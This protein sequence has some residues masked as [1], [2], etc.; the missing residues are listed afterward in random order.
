MNWNTHKG[1]ELADEPIAQGGINLN[2]NFERL[3]DRQLYL[4][5][6]KT[7]AYTAV[8][9]DLV[10]VDTSSANVT[11][12]LP[13]SPV[14]ND[15]IGV[16]LQSAGS[17]AAT[18]ARNGKKID[19]LS[20]DWTLDVSGAIVVL[21]Y[22]AS[23]GDWMIVEERW[24]ALVPS[25]SPAEGQALFYGDDGAAVW[26]SDFRRKNAVFNPF[27]L[28]NQRGEDPYSDPDSG[29]YTVDRWNVQRDDDAVVDVDSVTNQAPTVAQAGYRV[30]SSI[31]LAVNTTAD[32]SLGAS[33]YYL[34][35]QKIEGYVWSR[36]AQRD[37]TLSFW[38][39]SSKT[40]TYCVALRNSGKD[41]CYVAEY[42]IDAADTWEYKTISISAS[43]SA[44]TWN[45]ATSV[46]IDLSFA[47]AAHSSL[48]GTADSWNTSDKFSTSN[49]VNWLD[50]TDAEFHLT[51]VQLEV[52][53]SATELEDVSRE[54]ELLR[55]MRYFHKSYNIETAPGTS[56]S[57]GSISFR[58]TP[59][60]TTLNI[61]ISSKFPIPMRSSPTL[62]VYAQDGTKDK[63]TVASNKY[64]VG[65]SATGQIHFWAE[66]SATDSAAYTNPGIVA[67][68]TVDAE[69]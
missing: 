14:D 69:L 66:A 30:P 49:Q 63:I 20:A 33:Q 10:V 44:G 53:D 24:P 51:A 11:I 31:H 68:Y 38:V 4:T 23:A 59:Y 22:L 3:A 13:A 26:V 55:C 28:V 39:R 2:N 18:I 67:H 40:G 50:A 42:T 48:G 45:Y 58:M 65:A 61:R 52:G 21:Q 46:G 19:G 43:P 16:K 17:N 8:P 60:T 12:T 47:L 6:V 32:S 37:L 41:R 62:T 64:S 7:A 54:E 1:I 34:L 25:S 27:G 9:G 57:V 15:L 5:G 35:S 56:T 36:F 29:D